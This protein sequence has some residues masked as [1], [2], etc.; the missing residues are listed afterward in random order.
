MAVHEVEVQ[1]SSIFTSIYLLTAITC[2]LVSIG[3]AVLEMYALLPISIG[4]L[5]ALLVFRALPYEEYT[6]V[7]YSVP[8]RP[9][10]T[11]YCFVIAVLVGSTGVLGVSLLSY[12]VLALVA[13]AA[14]AICVSEQVRDWLRVVVIGS[15]TATVALFG[16]LAHPERMWEPDTYS[17]HGP[18]ISDI[19][20]TG[21]LPLATENRTI[22]PMQHLQVA[23]TDLITEA[24]TLDAYILFAGGLSIGICVTI[25]ALVRLILDSRIAALAAL[26]PSIGDYGHFAITHP[27]KM[28]FGYGMLI[29]LLFAIVLYQRQV[30]S[31]SPI[32]RGAFLATIAI[33]GIVMASIHP[34]SGVVAAAV[35][36]LYAI[37]STDIHVR[38]AVS[39]YFVALVAQVTIIGYPEWTSFL[40]AAIVDVAD[41]FAAGAESAA[42]EGGD[43]IHQQ[44]PVALVFHSLGTTITLIGVTWGGLWL[45]RDSDRTWK[46]RFPIVLSGVLLA[47]IAIGMITNLRYILP[48]RWYLLGYL[49]AFNILFAIG[50]ARIG[51]RGTS[52][53]AIAVI[54]L[55]G[56]MTAIAGYSTAVMYDQPYFKSY[57]E[58]DDFVADEWQETHLDSVVGAYGPQGGGG[59]GDIE[60]TDKGTFVPQD[61]TPIMYSDTYADSGVIAEGDGMQV[62][63]REYIRV[64]DDGLSDQSHVVYETGSTRV[65]VPTDVE[66]EQTSE[67]E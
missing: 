52:V 58:A 32:S 59:V 9:A 17:V 41:L 55:I 15:F 45:L 5:L 57:G 28:T 11:S 63:N 25:F 4:V 54:A 53:I 31:N 36:V 67:S 10:L 60:V 22:F 27:G 48:Q 61:D 49:I 21:S 65:Y 40:G 50:V 64:T 24:G 12:V 8:L 66:Q 7:E 26:V 20:S 39:I 2:A 14:A 47:V 37:I 35:L 16:Q 43:R 44:S 13:A 30:T 33:I 19:V 3:I 23:G 56:P 46:Y 18:I 29:V 6:I 62:G 42:Q 1:W 38:H 34:F 51:W